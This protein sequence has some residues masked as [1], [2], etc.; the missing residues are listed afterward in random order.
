MLT[1]L[2]KYIHTG[3]S[4]SALVM[5]IEIQHQK[6]YSFKPKKPQNPS[7]NCYSMQDPPQDFL[8]TLCCRGG[9]GGGPGGQ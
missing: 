9:P 1:I 8:I 6:I 7:S 2:K 3:Y 5:Y 4:A